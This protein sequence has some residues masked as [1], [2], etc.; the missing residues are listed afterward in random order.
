MKRLLW[1]AAFGFFVSC[2][3]HEEYTPPSPIE[4]K[5]RR[6]KPP[7]FEQ[8]VSVDK[9]GDEGL[10]PVD[11]EEKVED[12]DHRIEQQMKIQDDIA[13]AERKNRA[14]KLT[15]VAKKNIKIERK[16]AGQIPVTK[17]SKVKTVVPAP[18]PVKPVEKPVLSD[19]SDDDL[20]D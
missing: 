7:V 15:E 6:T 14:H 5:P 20:E 17:T 10:E 3:M 11:I 9:F 12:F 19:D 18:K 2:S 13:I 4:L 1:L 16:T 8:D